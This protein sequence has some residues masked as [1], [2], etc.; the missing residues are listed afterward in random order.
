MI[1]IFLING[2]RHEKIEGIDDSLLKNREILFIEQEVPSKP[3]TYQ[4]Q[5]IPATSVVDYVVSVY[6][7][8][9]QYNVNH[10]MYV[11]DKYPEVEMQDA[12]TR[13]IGIFSRM[14]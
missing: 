7:L 3:L 14:A 2:P 4:E 11:M 10:M 5:Y 8:Y 12:P 13:W 6:E 9:D 1:S